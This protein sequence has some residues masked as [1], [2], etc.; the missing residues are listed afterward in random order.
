MTEALQTPMGNFLLIPVY[1]DTDKELWEE[2][3]AGF[4]MTQTVR[5]GP[6]V[7]HT[8]TLNGCSIAKLRGSFVV[9]LK[10]NNA[11]TFNKLRQDIAAG[12]DRIKTI[13]PMKIE[14]GGFTVLTLTTQQQAT[15]GRRFSN[16]ENNAEILRHLAT[17][18]GVGGF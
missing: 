1:N 9:M 7:S 17:L 12:I 14:H 16:D 3:A 8:I 13:T 11:T 18:S 15:E 10:V 2:M 5:Y 6:E 4:G